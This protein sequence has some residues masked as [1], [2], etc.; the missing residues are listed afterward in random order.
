LYSGVSPECDIDGAHFS[1]GSLHLVSERL[2]KAPT[3][4]ANMSDA[5]TTSCFVRNSTLNF[6]L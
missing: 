2:I 1:A 5:K 4:A 3:I 6:P